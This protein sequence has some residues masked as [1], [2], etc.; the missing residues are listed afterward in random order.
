MKIMISLLTII[1]NKGQN[2]F[3]NLQIKFT[4]D[5]IFFVYENNFFMCDKIYFICKTVCLIYDKKN[6]L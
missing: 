2:L 6:R 1:D 3:Q 4:L 5:K